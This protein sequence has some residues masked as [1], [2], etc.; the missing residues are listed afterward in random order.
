MS[1]D[2][3]IT[4]E[5]VT[6]PPA[7]VPVDAPAPLPEPPPD[8]QPPPET[9]APA[10]DVPPPSNSPEP[11]PPIPSPPDPLPVPSP[12][13]A[14]PVPAPPAET[15]EPPSNPPPAVNGIPA[16]VLA[17]TDEELRHAATYFLQKNQA[18]FA[19][20]G[21]KARQDRKQQ[22]LDRI[23][24]YIQAHK[25]AQIPRLSHDL[26]L[27]PINTGY[28]LRVLLEQKKIK[29]EGWAKNRRYFI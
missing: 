13:P 5:S 28:Y 26:N 7:N 24:A 15:P 29:A 6:L 11:A 12:P 4:D 14:E 27:S 23:L 9:V 3:P 20:K 8:P 16:A 18:E 22:N 21:L 2:T 25:S 1:E 10:P 17:L 19:R